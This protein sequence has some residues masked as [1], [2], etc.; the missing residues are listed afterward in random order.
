M[1]KK[2]FVG[3]SAKGT[4][5]KKS[6]GSFKL[7]WLK[8]IVTTGAPDFKNVNVELSSI[9]EYPYENGLKCKIC[10]TCSS[11]KTNTANEYATGKQC[12]A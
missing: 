9:Y 2:N 5:H 12:E 4:Q 11:F 10:A 6:R 3:L 7:G 8:V 1:S